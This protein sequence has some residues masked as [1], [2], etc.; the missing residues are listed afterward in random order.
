MGTSLVRN[1]LCPP[2][3]PPP[4]PGLNILHPFCMAKISRSHVN[5]ILKPV[6]PPFSMAK[7]CSAPPPICKGKLHCFI[8]NCMFYQL[9]HVEHRGSSTQSWSRVLPFID[10]TRDQKGC[11]LLFSKSGIFLCIG[12]SNP[13]HPQPLGGCG[14]H[15]E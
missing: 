12:H 3:L 8:F 14:P 2:P 7:T 1:F 13:T 11:P 6:V 5:N 9:L 4:R 15:Q 10:E